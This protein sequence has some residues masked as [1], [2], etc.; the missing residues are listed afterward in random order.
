[1][2]PL[3]TLLH[4]ISSGLMPCAGWPRQASCLPLLPLQQL[5]DHLHLCTCSELSFHP[6][7]SFCLCRPNGA[8]AASA[9][10]S[11]RHS[12]QS[13]ASGR[14]NTSEHSNASAVALSLPGKMSPAAYTNAVASGTMRQRA[15]QAWSP[16]AGLEPLPEEG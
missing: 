12:V 9:G 8:R 16:D 2:L 15:K 10:R 7:L 1:M 14:S 13:E 5:R 6:P 3:Q 4:T 11:G